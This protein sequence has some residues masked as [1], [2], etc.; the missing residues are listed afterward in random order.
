MAT[1]HHAVPPTNSLQSKA[2]S[3]SL[4]PIPLTFANTRQDEFRER[5]SSLSPSCTSSDFTLLFCTNTS[6]HL[7]GTLLKSWWMYP[8]H[9]K[10]S[11]S[12]FPNKYFLLLL[13]KLEA[14]QRG[15]HQ[16]AKTL[17]L[18]RHAT[19]SQTQI[20]EDGKCGN[21]TDIKASGTEG[22]ANIFVQMLGSMMPKH[23]SFRES[24]A[25]RSISVPVQSSAGRFHQSES[26]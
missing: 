1:H 3:I 25:L 26:P 4:Q 9:L 5:L 14:P 8:P 21:W 13:L 17:I 22:T 15:R 11:A 23:R 2:R 6:A 19:A 16:D 10:A 24:L 18:A 7:Q 20:R 12:D